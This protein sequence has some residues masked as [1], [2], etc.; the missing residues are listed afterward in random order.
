MQKVERYGNLGSIKPSGEKNFE[1]ETV[2][3]DNDNDDDDDDKVKV[4]GNLTLQRQPI[5]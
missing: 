1:K 2:E 5:M 4:T 3:E